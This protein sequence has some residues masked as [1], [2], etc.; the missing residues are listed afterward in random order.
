LNVDSTFRDRTRARALCG[1]HARRGDYVGW[2][3]AL[4]DEAGGD[5]G[6]VPWADLEPNPYLVEWH[7][8]S[9][10]DL[11][12]RRCLEVGCGLGDDAE[13]LAAAGG[14]VTAF[15]VAATAIAWCRGRFPSSP[16]EYR[17]ADLLA[18]PAEWRRRFDL[19]VESYTLQVLPPEVRARAIGCVA[20]L[21]APG[22]ALLVICR[23]REA[24][25]PPGALPWPLVRAE[26]GAFASAG[27]R[28]AGFEDFLDAETPPV[29]RFRVEYRRPF[30]APGG[31]GS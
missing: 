22:G 25:D 12:G 29:R 30:D 17:V 13:Y 31:S 27:L 24:A 10:I 9:G 21:V 2:F 19:V 28:E 5:A 6:A 26:L 20:D 1:E 4:Y 8:R 14:I 23:G 11:R 15:D 18:A 16:V 3:E 7:R